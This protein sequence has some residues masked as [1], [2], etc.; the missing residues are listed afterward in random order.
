MDLIEF[1]DSPD[2][3]I[4][5]NTY[6][7]E[8]QH[9]NQPSLR[10]QVQ[11]MRQDGDNIF[12]DFTVWWLYEQKLGILPIQ[13]MTTLKVNSSHYTGWRNIPK[14]L[15]ERLPD[16]DIEG[17]MTFII[18]DVLNRFLN[19]DAAKAIG[20]EDYGD[21]APF[22]LKP[23][24]ANSGSTVMYGEGGLSKS[25]L[26]LA[27]AVSVSTGVPIFGK[28]PT[29]VGPVLYFD[30]EDDASAHARRLQALCR[31][32]G[33][34]M[35]EVNI[36]HKALVS[37]VTTSKRA[38]TKEVEDAGAVLGI[39][40]S[41]GMGRGGSATAAEDTIRMFRALREVGVP[42]LCIDHVSKEA[43]DKKGADV[44]A[45]GSIYTMNSARLA[46]SLVRQ[47]SGSGDAILIHAKNTKANHV[48]RALPQTIKIEYHNDER[49]VPE[50]IDIETGNEFGMMLPTVGTRER[51][52]MSLAHGEWR[53]YGEIEEELGVPSATIRQMVARD[54]TSVFEV[55][56]TPGKPNRL[57][58]DKNGVTPPVTPPPDEGQEVESE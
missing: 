15:S 36:F 23:F 44:D 18:N 50:C 20:S 45:Y 13:P 52:M 14:A 40:D 11:D 53:T 19:G 46:W 48:Q 1:N 22:I 47:H 2:I 35:S 32:F 29:V 37:K 42:F 24:I 5:R 27:M 3:H 31:S 8:W 43:K 28:A 34:P 30:Y 38:M 56:S 12:A 39:L 4:G 49:G 51:V 7:Y 57:R 10:V 41:V 26:A 54:M 25:L 6:G 33:I 21:D 55:E 17:A 9:N 58:C 16:V